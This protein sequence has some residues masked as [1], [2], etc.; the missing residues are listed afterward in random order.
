MLDPLYNFDHVL[1]AAISKESGQNQKLLPLMCDT[2][3]NL[4]SHMVGSNG[5]GG[6]NAINAVSLNSETVSTA[7]TGNAAV[8]VLYLYDR[9][10]FAWYRNNSNEGSSLV[11]SA[12]RTADAQS[13]DQSNVN[14]RGAHIIVNVSAIGGAAPSITP[15]IQGK[16]P[17]SGN[18]YDILVGSAISTTGINV[19]KVYPGIA[20]SPNAAANDILPRT[21][22][23]SVVHA[24]ADS[25]TYSVAANIMT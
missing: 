22:R 18:Y 2:N 8:S 1:I 24:N 10:N 4:F 6:S 11:A 23:V 13:T 12:A 3:G 25:I 17:V 19:I 5:F 7:Y 20:N 9:A 14:Q 21:W 15:K 16:D